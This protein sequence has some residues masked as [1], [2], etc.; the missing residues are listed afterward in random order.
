MKY[1]LPLILAIVA[2]SVSAG[3]CP[4][5]HGPNRDNVSSDKGLLKTWPEGGPTRL[6]EPPMA[7][8]GY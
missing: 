7:S 3:H 1:A 4:Q 6:W 5:F 8:P 2:V